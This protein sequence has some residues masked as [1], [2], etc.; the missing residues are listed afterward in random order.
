MTK[1][2]KRSSKTWPRKKSIKKTVLTIDNPAGP[3][4]Y[5]IAKDA[6]I[7]VVLYRGSYGKGAVKA[8][9]AFKKGEMTGRDID[10]IVEDL[11]K[12]LPEKK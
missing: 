2:W 9:R 12:I 11:A 5:D 1:D 7:T 10:G 6:D 8:N 4:D 3:R